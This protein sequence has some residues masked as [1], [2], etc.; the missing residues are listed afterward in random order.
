M[1]QR[2]KPR[3]GVGETCG[4]GFGLGRHRMV[5]SIGHSGKRV[6]GGIRIPAVRARLRDYREP[7]R[8]YNVRFSRRDW[9]LL[10][11]IQ[12]R[13]VHWTGYMAGM[14]FPNRIA[15]HVLS[16]VRLI[17]GRVVE[18]PKRFAEDCHD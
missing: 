18:V 5:K 10:D 3:Q 15:R 12:A 16:P 14:S 11:D 13:E 7:A 2:D 9:N 1:S 17:F 8:V 4:S 6:L